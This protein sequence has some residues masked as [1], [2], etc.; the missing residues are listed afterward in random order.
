[1]IL[2]WRSFDRSQAEPS[3]SRRLRGAGVARHLGAEVQ[4]SLRS[5]CTLRPTAMDVSR[6][7][8]KCTLHR[9]ST[10]EACA[11]PAGSPLALSLADCDIAAW[12]HVRAYTAA[13]SATSR[14]SRESS[15]S[16]TA[17][18]PQQH[19]R[20]CGG[21]SRAEA[22]KRSVHGPSTTTSSFGAGYINALILPLQRG[23]AC[24]S[25]RH[26]RLMHSRVVLL[27]A[28][29]LAL[30]EGAHGYARVRIGASPATLECERLRCAGS[31]FEPRASRF[32]SSSLIMQGGSRP[33]LR[34]ARRFSGRRPRNP[35]S[36]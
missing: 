18:S 8:R 7:S 17:I 31:V 15:H 4:S 25:T 21:A 12:A 22:L 14:R 26:P 1:M 20:T 36:R 9:C 24:A 11:R 29:L 23:L 30:W 19:P 2:A 16:N 3:E 13:R 28:H 10:R 6:Q 5:G 33:S 35:A 27:V 32:R 34:G